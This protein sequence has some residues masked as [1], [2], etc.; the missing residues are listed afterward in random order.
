MSLVD[1]LGLQVAT[2]QGIGEIVNH[3]DWVARIQGDNFW[4]SEDFAPERKM[5][6]RLRRGEATPYDW[7]FWRHEIAEARACRSHRTLPTDEALR[8]QREAHERI[9]RQQGGSKWNRY[10]PSA[11][12]DPSRF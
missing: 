5:V 6:E 1:P 2:Y 12:T 10:H 7:A 11:I 8:G 4:K 3:L 9:E